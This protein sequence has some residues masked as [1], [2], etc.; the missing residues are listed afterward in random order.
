MFDEAKVEALLKAWDTACKAEGLEAR[1]TTYDVYIRLA[2]EASHD[3]LVEFNR[4]S[5][6]Y[7]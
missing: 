7:K 5:L 1:D 4:R 3:D 6:E 2:E